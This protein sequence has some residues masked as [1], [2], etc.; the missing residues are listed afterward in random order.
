MYECTYLTRAE[1]VTRGCTTAAELL[2]K[3]EIT[4][5][6]LDLNAQ[7]IL[8]IR[9]CLDAGTY[10]HFPSLKADVA[11]RIELITQRL[12]WD[13]CE[14][15]MQDFWYEWLT[16]EIGD[17]EAQPG[18]YKRND[19]VR[20]VDVLYAL[21][22]DLDDVEALEALFGRSVWLSTPIL[23]LDRMADY[24]ERAARA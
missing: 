16:D 1:G 3:R 14:L 5:M 24:A 21:G 12:V 19:Y 10:E 7:E 9:A 8:G 13:V 15:E 2:H 22:C 6:V 18:D 23:E 17:V 20:V 4:R 11:A